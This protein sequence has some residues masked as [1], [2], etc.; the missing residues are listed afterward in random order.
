L[1]AFTSISDYHQQ[2]LSGSTTCVATVTHYL[3]QIEQQQQLNAFNR[4]YA[5]EAHERAALLDAQQASGLPL[6]KLHGV[7]VGIKDVLNYIQHPVTASSHMLQNYV[8]GYNATV[9]QKILDEGAIIIGHQNCDEF[10]M[11]S[12]NE[13]SYFG[14]VSN[15]VDNNRVPGGSSGGSAV[16][17]QAGL[18]MVSLGSDTGGSVRQPADFCGVVGLKPSYG[19]VSRYGLIAYAS[20]FDQVGILSC[21]V[22][23]AALV[24]EVIAGKDEYDATVYQ[25]PVP[26]YTGLLKEPATTKRIGYFTE[27]LH[28]PSLD[29]EIRNAIEQQIQKLKEEGYTVEARSFNLID[30]LVPTY[31]ILTTAEA[32]SNLSRYDGVRYGYRDDIPGQDLI[33]F[34][35]TNRS[36]GFGAEV[37]R[38]IMLGNFVLSAGYYDAYYTKAQQ[39]RRLLYDLAKQLFED[40]DFLLM[41]NSPFTAFE[42]G[43]KKQDPLE[44]YLAD[45][46]TVFA[47]LAGLPA[48]SLPLYQHTNG[49]PFGLQVLANQQNE[50]GLLRFSHQ[51]MQQK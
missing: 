4:V 39:V 28:H 32:A 27:A 50:A 20:S 41:P 2:L 3:Q 18:C 49:M 13:N 26:S 24:L 47:N 14:S 44:M 46:Y 19:R 29:V 42:K 33:S 8:A 30:Y 10:A 11:G 48:I 1:T 5:N 37:K 35:K 31:Y 45:I 40:C 12:S 25:T 16:S 51:L 15:A 22:P 43:E 7:V 6:K 34:Y 36:N 23:D 17:V 21:N 38:R 9:V